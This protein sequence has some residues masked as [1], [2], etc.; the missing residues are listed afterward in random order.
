MCGTKM[1]DDFTELCQGSIEQLEND[2]RRQQPSSKYRARQGVLP[3]TVQAVSDVVQVILDGLRRLLHNL[4]P[5]LLSRY[6]KP[7]ATLP[8][9]MVTQPIQGNGN[10]QP[11]L[12]A[13]L[14]IDKSATLTTLCQEQ[15][16][17]ISTDRH[18]LSI[19]K[20]KYFE[21]KSTKSWL[22]L[23]SLKCVC[24]T[25]VSLLLLLHCLYGLTVTQFAVD[26]SKCADTHS[27][28]SVCLA[29]CVCLPPV[30]MVDKE[31]ECGPAPRDP[32]PG[33]SPAIGPNY[34]THCLLHPEMIDSTQKSLLLQ[35]PKLMNGPL[36]TSSS[37]YTV[38][39]GLHFQEGWHLRTIWCFLVFIVVAS[40]LLGIVWSVVRDDVQGGFGISSY[41]IT[42]GALGVGYL[43][44]S[45]GRG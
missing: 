35:I 41:L 36:T 13:L 45:D 44:I 26:H 27:H 38:G 17:S 39:W 7:S 15:L 11:S 6:N 1:F 31:Y 9:V 8:T 19:L 25:R 42:I 33:L 29:D 10:S 30:S 12:R 43:A 20:A 18:L 5:R 16:D 37:K 21:N 23:R 24:L 40:L 34:L 28:N 4:K 22:T 14:C 32:L 3:E 2:L